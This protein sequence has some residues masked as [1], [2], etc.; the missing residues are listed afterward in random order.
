MDKLVSVV[1]PVYNQEKKIKRCVDS[2]LMQTYKTVEIIL[3]DDGSTDN[4]FTLCKVYQNE[5]NRVHVI[6]QRNQG[7]S[8]ARNTGLEYAAGEFVMFV[9]SDDYVSKTYVQKMVETITEK[10]CDCVFCGIERFFSDGTH[11]S[12]SMEQ[13]EWNVRNASE[14]FEKVFEAK[15]LNAPVNKIYRKNQIKS[16]FCKELSIGEDLLFNLDYVQNSQMI[17]II[18]DILYFYDAAS[19]GSL[20]KTI[21]ANELECQQ[22]MYFDTLE[23]FKTLYGSFS[24]IILASYLRTILYRILLFRFQTDGKISK[25]LLNK[26]KNDRLVIMAINKVKLTYAFEKIAVHFIQRGWVISVNIIYKIYIRR[27]RLFDNVK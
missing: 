16:F 23:C 22:K 21:R 17:V 6:H 4:S 25:K 9:D 5:D 13:V 1:V 12:F 27:N 3:V 7:V 15:L 11:N 2:L 14:V 8:V 18:P 20:F 26:I 24:S 19:E 10:N